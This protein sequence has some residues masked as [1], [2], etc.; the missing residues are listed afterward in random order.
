MKNVPHPN[1]FEE[2]NEETGNNRIMRSMGR[3]YAH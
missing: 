2:G 1:Y 3:K